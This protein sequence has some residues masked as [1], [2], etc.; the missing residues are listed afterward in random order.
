MTPAQPTGEKIKITPRNTTTTSEKIERTPRPKKGKKIGKV[1]D[2]IKDDEEKKKLQIQYTI[3]DKRQEGLKLVGN[4]MYGGLA[5][6][7]SETPFYPA[8]A[9]T[10]AMGR[11]SI[12]DAIDYTVKKYT[13]SNLYGQEEKKYLAVVIYDFA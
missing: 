11:F 8:A 4:S 10:T 12:Q 5:S 7:Y 6:D 2:S 9:C 13:V 1:I 3:Y